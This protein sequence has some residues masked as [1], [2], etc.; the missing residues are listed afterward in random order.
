MRASSFRGVAH[1]SRRLDLAAG[2]RV[3]LGRVVAVDP[4]RQGLDDGVDDDQNFED[5]KSELED[6]ET[7]DSGALDGAPREHAAA[8][9]DDDK[10]ALLGAREKPPPPPP[11][12]L[13]EFAALAPRGA[14]AAAGN[15]SSDSGVGL[16]PALGCAASARNGMMGAGACAIAAGSSA[17]AT[18]GHAPPNPGLSGVPSATASMSMPC[19]MRM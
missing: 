13:I 18:L 17:T 1:L 3:V 7:N 19:E 4:R 15:M 11:G 6:F 16:A 14:P 5:A 2:A 9:L 12:E 10:R 8:P